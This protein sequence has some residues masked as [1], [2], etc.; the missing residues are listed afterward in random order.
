LSF[1]IKT[2]NDRYNGVTEGVAFANGVGETDDENVKNVLI[3]DYGYSVVEEPEKKA[4]S[5]KKKEPKK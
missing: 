4:E 5:P 2:P 1:K 3:N